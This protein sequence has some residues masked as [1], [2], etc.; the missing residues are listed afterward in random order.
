MEMM[1]HMARTSVDIF[2][3]NYENLIDSVCIDD[4]RVMISELLPRGNVDMKPYNEVLKSL[5]ADS[6]VEFVENY[7]SFLLA[8]GEMLDTYLYDDQVHINASGTRR[9]LANFDRLHQVT[10]TSKAPARKPYQNRN[11]AGFLA[12][13]AGPPRYTKPFRQSNQLCHI[14]DRYGGHN[15]KECWYNGRN[16]GFQSRSR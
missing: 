4:S 16:A 14:C 15:T 13:R 6:A 1:L 11:C 2:R 9:L 8:S 3:Q 12:F 5:C 7:N 10:S